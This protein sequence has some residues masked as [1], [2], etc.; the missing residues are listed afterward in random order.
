MGNP[1]AN[2]TSLGIQ[3]GKTKVFL[4]H[5]AFE[6]LERIRSIEITRAAVKLN[7]IFRMYLARTAYLHFK[8][9]FSE[10]PH[11]GDE[12]KETKESEDYIYGSQIG[13]FLERRSY[14]TGECPSLVDLWASQGRRGSIHNPFRRSD[15]GKD[16]PSGPF[17]WSFV[18]GYWIKNY[19]VEQRVEPS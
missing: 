6:S 3:L 12:F 5:E 17:K 1:K 16:G 7:S 9:F 4:R 8:A 11:Y 2:G 14:Y 18:E 13:D 15:C 10:N 19:D